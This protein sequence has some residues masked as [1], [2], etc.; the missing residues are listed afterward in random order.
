M[1]NNLMNEKKF[2]SSWSGGKDSCLS[3]YRT[4][5]NGGKP[6]L[7]FTMMIESGEISRSHGLPPG[8]LK[9]Q[10]ESLNIPIVFAAAS[11]ESYE[12][13]FIDQ[14]NK[15][16]AQGIDH[17]VFGDIDIMHHLEW[18]TRVCE[19]AGITAQEPLWQ[20][21]RTALLT[22]FIDLSFKAMIVSIN[23][24]H[25]TEDFLGQIINFDLIEKMKHAGIDPSGEQGG[26]HTLVVDGPLFSFPI[27]VQPESHYNHQDYCFLNLK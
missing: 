3:L 2:F 27:D 14:L 7:L 22:E 11:W 17:G 15:I 24:K 1:N 4:I 13:V 12:D 16:K 8:L 25:L 19:Q 9:T 20:E 18:V 26:Y 5:Q 6:D 21:E 23:K 10:A